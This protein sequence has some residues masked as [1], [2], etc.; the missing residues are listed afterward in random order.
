M[1]FG[2]DL[3]TTNSLIAVFRDGKP[4]LITNALGQVLTPSVVAVTAEGIVVGQAAREIALS[5]PTASA[6][7]F[8]RAMG[9]DRS[10]TLSGKSFTAPELSALVLS[11]LKADAEAHLGVQVR[12][13]VI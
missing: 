9:T 11:A 4:E 10:Y 8:K 7:V 6:A 12:D 1:H 13:V 5:D 2:I 3:G